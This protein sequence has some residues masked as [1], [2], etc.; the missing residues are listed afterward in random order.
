MRN[1]TLIYILVLSVLTSNLVFVSNSYAQ[2]KKERVVLVT[3]DKVTEGMTSP[4]I[5]LTGSTYF[6]EKSKVA[7]ES[8]GLVK[9]VYINEGDAVEVGQPIAKLDDSLMKYNL[10]AAVAETKHAKS[11]LDKAKRDYKRTKI[12]FDQKSLS[13]ATY[14][15]AMTDMQKAE[16]TYLV[17][18]ANQQR[19][20]VEFKKMT[21]LSPLK[22]VVIS[23]NVEVGE[24]VNAGSQVAGVATLSYITKVYIP[25]TVL[26]YLRVGEEVTV[27]TK[28]KEYNGRVL[29]I[30]PQGDTATRLFLTRIYIGQD[31]NLKEGLHA[32]AL[33]PSGSKVKALL[34]PR[35][36]LIERNSVKG[37][38]VV[39]ED[40]KAKF[41]PIKII[42]YN[43]GYLAISPVVQGNIDVNNYVI[44]D[45]NNAVT[46][47][48]KVKIT[49]KIK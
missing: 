31:P 48:V 22:G 49:S 10:Q 47:G 42:G 14:D 7:A 6:S 25:E 3:I 27:K 40:S 11:V 20:E 23:K 17:S 41:V 15:D 33:I 46:N 38:Y 26:P 37:V 29:S 36:A 12:L 35:D 21:I 2:T 19:L 1:F 30:N 9:K 16:N 44:L 45:G 32:T 34:V 28:R 4:T 13:K 39:T 24:W 43:G 8:A 18:L 5:L